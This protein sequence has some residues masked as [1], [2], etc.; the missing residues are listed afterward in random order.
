MK[1]DRLKLIDERLER[2][3]KMLMAQ[4]TVLDLDE[5]VLYTGYSRG[6]LYKLTSK[7]QIP[8]YKKSRKIFFNRTELD[9]WLQ[10][11]RIKTDEEIESEAQTYCRTHK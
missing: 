2:I 5:A 10:E 8:H 4:K 3:E 7:K 11:Q 1:T 9:E 6:Y